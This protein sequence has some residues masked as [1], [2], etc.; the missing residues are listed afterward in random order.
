MIEKRFDISGFEAH[1]RRVHKRVGLEP[2]GVQKL[3]I[4]VH[5][6]E[7][8][9]IVHER[10]DTDRTRLDAQ[11]IFQ[12]FRRSEA[13]AFY[14]QPLTK[15][16]QIELLVLGE[17]HEEVLLPFLIFEKKIFVLQAR[18]G[19]AELLRLFAGEDGRVLERLEFDAEL[20]E[21]IRYHVVCLEFAIC[22]TSERIPAAVTSTPA[23]GP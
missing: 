8:L 7:C 13:E 16:L 3:L 9:S 15:L 1:G 14:A 22:S 19:R 11:D 2:F 4:D 6:R 23:P 12:A 17:A 21:E 5:L 10:K 18:H 20:G